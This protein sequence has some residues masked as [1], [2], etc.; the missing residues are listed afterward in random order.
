MRPALDNVEDET[1]INFEFTYL[2][3]RNKLH[4]IR[5]FH[6]LKF[7]LHSSNLKTLPTKVKDWGR[8]KIKRVMETESGVGPNM[9]I[10]RGN[11]R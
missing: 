3:A 9:I 11:G 7:F 10:F 5:C 8:D 6:I 4:D 1:A 2:Q